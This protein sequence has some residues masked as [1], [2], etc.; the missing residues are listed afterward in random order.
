MNNKD[1]NNVTD[2][3]LRHF[4][5]GISFKDTF[6]SFVVSDDDDDDDNGVVGE[7]NEREEWRDE[8]LTESLILENLQ[9]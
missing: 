3:I 7:K 2:V 4:L 1:I 5:W 6:L 8:R 9:V